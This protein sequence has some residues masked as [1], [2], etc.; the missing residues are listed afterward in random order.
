MDV[1]FM[2]PPRQTTA[3]AGPSVSKGKDLSLLLKPGEKYQT[4][5]DLLY[6]RETM[7][8]TKNMPRRQTTQAGKMP[9]KQFATKN[10]IKAG[11]GNPPCMGGIKKPFRYHPGTVALRE[12]RRYQKST[13]LLIRK[14]PFN[15]LVREI[16]QDIKT[17]L[18]FQAQ[19]IGALQVT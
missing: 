6:F 11:K 3:Q 15:R 14:L 8:R 17:N 2:T 5:Q 1:P 16:A 13:E 19:A 4:P 18:R 9:R 10:L 7:P 12:I